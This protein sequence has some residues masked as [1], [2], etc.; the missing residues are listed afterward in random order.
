MGKPVLQRGQR[1]IYSYLVSPIQNTLSRWNKNQSL[2]KLL[3]CKPPTDPSTDRQ[4][5]FKLPQTLSKPIK[6]SYLP[7]KICP[8]CNRPFNWRKKWEKQW[9]SVTYCS[10]KCR[11]LKKEKKQ[12]RHGENKPPRK[13]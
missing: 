1:F 11:N 7:S 4:V 13:G 2:S 12:F 3:I 8:V 6:K 9:E 10:D 5:F